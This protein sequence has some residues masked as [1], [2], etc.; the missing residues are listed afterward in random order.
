M[1][2]YAMASDPV[3]IREFKVFVKGQLQGADLAPLEAELYGS[4][5]RALGVLRASFLE[6]ALERYIR[7]HVRPNLDSDSA[8]RLFDFSGIVGSFGAKIL[9]AYALNWIGKD[10][11]HDLEL[12]RTMR[13]EFAHCRKAIRFTDPPVAA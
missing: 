1:G 11:H 6:A 12:I 7:A 13:N 2:A 10:T 4:S 3:Y 8:K 5:D 9:L